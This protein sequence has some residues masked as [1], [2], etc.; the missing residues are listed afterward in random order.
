MAV[1]GRVFTAAGAGPHP[2]GDKPTQHGPVASDRV[3]AFGTYLLGRQHLLVERGAECLE[4]CFGAL[5][6]TGWRR[7]CRRLLWTPL[8]RCWAQRD[9]C[10]RR[11]VSAWPP[12]SA[13]A[14]TMTRL[15]EMSGWSSSSRRPA[16]A[17]VPRT[18][19]A[20]SWRSGPTAPP[21]AS[22]A[23]T[24]S[25]GWSCSM[26]CSPARYGSPPPSSRAVNGAH[27]GQPPPATPNSP[28]GP[29]RP[30]PPDP[31]TS[32]RLI[33]DRP[34]AFAPQHRLIPAKGRYRLKHRREVRAGHLVLCDL[35]VVQRSQLALHAAI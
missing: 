33:V 10:L 34:V 24:A 5:V 22:T 11:A 14:S 30:A 25:T 18:A 1:D 9:G 12:T 21:L 15:S 7:Y 28:L 26:T 20:R 2:S 4:D 27:P 35:G 17:G 32:C 6:S 19:P 13:S 3:A 8:G 31:E 16:A 29:H 23:S